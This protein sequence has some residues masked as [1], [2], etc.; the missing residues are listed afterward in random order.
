[1]PNYE[2]VVGSQNLEIER[3]KTDNSVSFIFPKLN[4]DDEEIAIKIG[5]KESFL[6]ERKNYY[7]WTVSKEQ[8]QNIE[9]AF[10][11]LNSQITDFCKEEL[12]L[13]YMEIL[14]ENFSNKLIK[15]EEKINKADNCYVGAKISALT[16]LFRQSD[17][18]ELAISLAVQSIDY[19]KDL[20]MCFYRS[21]KIGNNFYQNVT[22]SLNENE[23]KEMFDEKMLEILGIR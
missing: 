2:T 16:A 19:L 15:K 7:D 18:L 6:N 13:D 11:E 8:K 23:Q 21:E 3:E 14:I 5:I 17:N 22:K 20:G 12:K 9:N 4:Q 1:M 10:I